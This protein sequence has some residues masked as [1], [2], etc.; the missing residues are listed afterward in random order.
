M[1]DQPEIPMMFNKADSTFFLCNVWKESVKMKS[2]KWT[3]IAFS[4]VS[5][6]CL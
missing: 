3:S 4:S 5:L 6:T 2:E 1:P